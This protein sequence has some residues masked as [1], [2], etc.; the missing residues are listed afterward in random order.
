[1]MNLFKPFSQNR[2]EKSFT[3]LETIIALGLMVSLSLEV[4]QLQGRSILISD[5]SRKSSQAMWIAKALMAKIEWGHHFYPLKEFKQ[6]RAK[7]EK[8]EE[9]L[10]RTVEGAPCEFTYSANVETWQ[11]PFFKL[12]TG[13]LGGSESEEEEGESPLKGMLE[14]YVK[15]ILDDEIMRVARVAVHW[16]E[17]IHRNEVSL[18]YLLTNQKSLDDF[19]E[20]DPLSKS[21]SGGN[22]AA[23]ESK[24]AG[25]E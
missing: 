3:L 19:I 22:K 18:S 4:S 9:G 2:G 24:A 8:L 25:G 11:L 21:S 17:G 20:K 14:K 15:E 6:V 1:M 10:C 7:E 13:G 5:Y 12:L 16:P 23:G